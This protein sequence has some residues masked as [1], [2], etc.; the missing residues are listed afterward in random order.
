MEALAKKGL[1]LPL[2]L[3]I[4]EDN[5]CRETK[6]I[7]FMTFC[8]LLVTMGMFK[9]ITVQFHRVGHTHGPIGQRF[10]IVATVISRQAV[11]E[12]MQDFADA[13]LRGVAPAGN[14]ILKVHICKRTYD[15][16][17][18]FWMKLGISTPGTTPDP[19]TGELHTNHCW[20]FIRRYNL[21]G[22]DEAKGDQW[23]P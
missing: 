18:W 9:S 22:Y 19:Q 3:I 14:R 23:V 21:P 10:S 8:G 20:R 2:H 12:V 15:F 7:P 6:N 17:N 5:T 11:L 13:I 4:Q 1:R 16:Q